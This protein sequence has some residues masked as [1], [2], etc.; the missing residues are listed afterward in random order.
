[1]S[2]TL[3][4]NGTIL[5]PS[6]KLQRKADLLIRDGKIAAIGSGVAKADEVIDAANE[7]GMLVANVPDT[8]PLRHRSS[9]LAEQPHPR[10]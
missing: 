2:S 8:T 10:R 4:Q 1:M 5:D 3:I 9:G 6:Q 7:Y